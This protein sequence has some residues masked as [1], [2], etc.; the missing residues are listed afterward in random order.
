MQ[1]NPEIFVVHPP[2]I[3]PFFEST[4][5]ASGYTPSK[6]AS[7]QRFRCWRARRIRSAPPVSCLSNY[8]AGRSI[9]GP[10][11]RKLEQDRKAGRDTTTIRRSTRRC[12]WSTEDCQE[13][14]EAD[15]DVRHFV[16]RKVFSSVCSS[17]RLSRFIF[18]VRPP[19]NPRL[20]SSPGKTSAIGLCL[21]E[22]WSCLVVW[23]AYVECVLDV[24][25]STLFPSKSESE[26][27]LDDM[28]LLMRAY[29]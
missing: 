26:S 14:E 17:N 16:G 12:T 1:N 28:A 8:A 5:I 22:C 7:C 6:W 2:F 20:V 11:S 25:Q 23:I 10:T 4:T 9:S 24:G 13:R 3:S 29:C 15:S 21:A 27:L 18:G 19:L